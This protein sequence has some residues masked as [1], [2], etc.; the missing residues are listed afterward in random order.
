MIEGEHWDKG[1]S[2]FLAGSASGIWVTAHPLE[3]LVRPARGP[4]PTPE[5]LQKFN[6]RGRFRG[7]T[8]EDDAAARSGLG[9][10]CDLQS[11]NSEDALTWSV[12]GP[13]IYSSPVKR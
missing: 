8:P 3:N 12:F 5:L 10:F 9:Y 4:W 7:K 6:A 13:L 2:I 1:R 11:L